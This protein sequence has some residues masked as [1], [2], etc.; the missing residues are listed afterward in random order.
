MRN[1]N[2]ECVYVLIHR[3]TYGESGG[4]TGLADSEHGGPGHA[5]HYR[6]T[7]AE[8]RQASLAHAFSGT[9]FK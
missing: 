4:F 5:L 2:D 7:T 9:E 3:F 1:T 8:Q 6:N